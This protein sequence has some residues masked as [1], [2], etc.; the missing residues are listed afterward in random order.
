MREGQ[1]PAESY[2]KSSHCTDAEGCETAPTE[3]SAI[4]PRFPTAAHAT[5]RALYDRMNVEVVEAGT[6]DER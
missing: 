4:T 3:V 6:P 5:P 1:L 2:W